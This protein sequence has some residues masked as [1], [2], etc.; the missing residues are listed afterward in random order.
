MSAT[1]VRPPAGVV[2]HLDEADRPKQELV[3]RNIANLLAELSDGTPIELVTNG[4][5]VGTS[6]LD[7]PE[8]AQ[9]RS[10]LDQGVA[11]VACNHSLQDLG[12][13]TDRLVDGVTV[14]PSGVA[15][16]VKRQRE[17]W[18]YLRP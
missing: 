16:L 14:V 4:P 12:I 2:F 10:L 17:G 15:E 6:L 5:G 9:L 1:V 8:A 13:S 7:S 3:L 18:A 11:V